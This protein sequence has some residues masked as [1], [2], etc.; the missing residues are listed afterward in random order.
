MNRLPE[1]LEDLK[2]VSPNAELRTEALV[3]YVYLPDLKLPLGDPPAVVDGLLC[4]Q[5]IHGYDSRLFLSRIIPG[6]GNNWR[7]FHILDREWHSPSWNGIPGSLRLIEILMGHLGM[8][9]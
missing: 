3:E 1:E 5:S 2:L 8:Y 4:P 9:R 7:S 6:K